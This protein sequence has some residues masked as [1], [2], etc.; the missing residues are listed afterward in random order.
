MSCYKTSNNK[1]F[2]CPPRMDDGRHFTDYRPR[3]LLNNIV[4]L[5]NNIR[6]SFQ[7]RLFLTRNASK[8]MEEKRQEFYNKY[9]CEP[10]DKPTTM[11]SEQNVVTCDKFNCYASVVDKNGLGQG[12]N[13]NNAKN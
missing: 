9:N 13:F 6:N 7:H 8:L 12:R 1:H 4:R 11:L 5:D 3:C 10:C 2:D